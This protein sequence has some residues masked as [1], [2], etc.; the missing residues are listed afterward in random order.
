[1][2]RLVTFKGVRRSPDARL[3]ERHKHSP[4]RSLTVRYPFA[5]AECFQATLR[6]V[7]GSSAGR[8]GR[9]GPADPAPCPSVRRPPDDVTG[10]GRFSPLVDTVLLGHALLL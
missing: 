2:A 9:S 5:Q 4:R 10:R 8:P 1:M 3:F 6:D 7:P